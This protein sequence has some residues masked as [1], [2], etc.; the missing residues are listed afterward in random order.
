MC[1]SSYSLFCLGEMSQDCDSSSVP[2][3]L[4]WMLN[5]ALSFSLVQCIDMLEHKVQAQLPFLS[6]E[7]KIQD[8]VHSPNCTKPCQALKVILSFF[9]G[10]C[11][12]MPGCWVQAPL[13]SIPPA[14]VVSGLCDFF[15]SCR[16]KLVAEIRVVCGS[17]PSTEMN[18]L[19]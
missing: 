13:L 11:I 12:E 9:L 1:T 14:E 16:N 2:A 10:Q 7:K 18:T 19:C 17:V 15:Q 8:C 3:E 4:C 6:P 5:A